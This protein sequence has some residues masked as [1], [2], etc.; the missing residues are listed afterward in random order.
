MTSSAE[1]VHPGHAE[2]WTGTP[3]A[4]LKTVVQPGTGVVA[5]CRM[6]VATSDP[7]VAQDLAWH[8][9]CAIPS[10]SEILAR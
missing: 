2:V 8:W 5:A 10:Q 1:W 9:D 3:V 6:A 7:R 4:D